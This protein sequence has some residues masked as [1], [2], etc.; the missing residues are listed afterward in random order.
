MLD[1]KV[2]QRRD[3]RGAICPALTT[4]GLHAQDAV[5]FERLGAEASLSPTQAFPG[6]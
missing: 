1:E 2:E 5:Q 3:A 6:S 4:P